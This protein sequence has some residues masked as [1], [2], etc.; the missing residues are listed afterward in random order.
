MVVK[1]KAV[2]RCRDMVAKDDKD[3]QIALLRDALEKIQD[4]AKQAIDD[5]SARVSFDKI[6]HIASTAL[7]DTTF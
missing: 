7:L 5:W 2:R 4:E 6:E 3:G 1:L